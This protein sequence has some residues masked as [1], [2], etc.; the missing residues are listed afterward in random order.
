MGATWF[1]DPALGLTAVL[2]TQRAQESPLPPPV[3]LDFWTS[4]YTAAR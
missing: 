3:S 1:N 2:M 4:A